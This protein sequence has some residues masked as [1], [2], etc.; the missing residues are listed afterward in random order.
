MIIIIEALAAQLRN[1]NPN[2]GWAKSIVEAT[3][4]IYRV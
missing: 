4:I 2:M 3:K 1:E